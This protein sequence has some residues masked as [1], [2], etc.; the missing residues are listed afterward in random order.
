MQN[1][2]LN[3]SAYSRFSYFYT[4]IFNN[5]QFKVWGEIF[6]TGWIR[7]ASFFDLFMVKNYI[8]VEPLT[9]YIE[10]TP[11]NCVAGYQIIVWVWC[12]ISD[13][14]SVEGVFTTD[15]S[16]VSI[17]ITAKVKEFYSHFFLGFVFRHVLFEFWVMPYG[18]IFWGEGVWFGAL[19]HHLCLGLLCFVTLR[20]NLF[21]HILSFSL[22]YPFWFFCR[23]QYLLSIFHLTKWRIYHHKVT[24]W[25]YI[26]Y[27]EHQCWRK[28][29][30][31]IFSLCNNT[32]SIWAY[33]K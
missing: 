15:V 1:P 19:R 31:Y 23:C 14:V 22:W 20:D 33:L 6:W 25:Y 30:P 12:R 27:V 7:L 32:K 28:N 26:Y 24:H 13:V 4:N 17:F 11:G 10:A 2:V 21:L 29:Q 5:D 3:A 8:P 16:E 18:M 9:L